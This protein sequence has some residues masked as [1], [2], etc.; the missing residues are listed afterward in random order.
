MFSRRNGLKSRSEVQTVR[1]GGGTDESSKEIN[2]SRQFKKFESVKEYVSAV[3]VYAECLAQIRGY[4]W[5]ARSLLMTLHRFNFLRFVSLILIL[6]VILI[7]PRSV[8]SDKTQQLKSLEEITDQLFERNRAR[9]R[10]SCP[11]LDENEI[12]STFKSFALENGLSADRLTTGSVYCAALGFHSTAG[13]LNDTSSLPLT[14]KKKRKNGFSPTQPPP[15]Q[16]RT[17]PAPDSSQQA[18]FLK[19]LNSA[20]RDFNTKV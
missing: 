11:P 5:T 7:F 4:D 10:Q 8:I 13:A 17:G 2:V 18:A 20:C 3:H 15:K 6:M 1:V 19:K 12:I 9:A 14:D 16:P